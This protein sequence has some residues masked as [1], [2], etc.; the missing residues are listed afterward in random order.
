MERPA[1]PGGHLPNLSYTWNFPRQ[2]QDKTV[3]L[4]W[5]NQT[6]VHQVMIVD[7]SI[8][9][10]FGSEVLLMLQ[11]CLEWQP[12]IAAIC[13]SQME[14]T[15]RQCKWRKQEPPRRKTWGGGLG[16]SR[17]TSQI[18]SNSLRDVTNCEGIQDPLFFNF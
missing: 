4:M 3:K 15:R 6:L 12:G 17:S 10:F 2:H 16:V 9:Q 18:S 7:N 14:S 11:L 8:T 13:V 5:D 1:D